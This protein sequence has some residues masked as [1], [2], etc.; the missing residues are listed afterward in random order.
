MSVT[1]GNDSKSNNQIVL[2]PHVCFV[3]RTAKKILGQ[4]FSVRLLDIVKS[5]KGNSWPQNR[6]V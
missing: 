2:R 4:H 6:R 1:L 5:C 3:S